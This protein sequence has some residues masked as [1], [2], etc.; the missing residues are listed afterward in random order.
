LQRP[1]GLPV[2]IDHW[3]GAGTDDAVLRPSFARGALLLRDPE[4]GMTRLSW[5]EVGPAGDVRRALAPGRYELLGVRWIEHDAAGAEWIA[6]ASGAASE[7]EIAPGRDD[8]AV[9]IASGKVVGG[10]K[11]RP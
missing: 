5:G 7:F 8:L 11:F 4:G 10:D 9:P 6:S 3:T 1:L 2:V